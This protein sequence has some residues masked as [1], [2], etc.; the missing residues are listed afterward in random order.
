MRYSFL[1]GIWNSGRTRALPVYGP[2]GTRDIVFALLTQVY[3]ADIR[4][5]LKV[6]EYIG[7]Q[8]LDPNDLVRIIE[9]DHDWLLSQTACTFR[10]ER[11]M[12]GHTMGMSFEELPCLGYRLSDGDSTI[13]ISGDTVDCAGLEKLATDVDVLILCCYLT[14]DEEREGGNGFVSEHIMVSS[15]DAGK[16]ATKYRVKKLVLTHIRQ[17]SADMINKM[18][19]EIADDYSGMIVVGKDL[20]EFHVP[21]Y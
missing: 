13:A 6:A 17:K 2:K 11:V 21:D 3:S 15:A 18:A 16:I 20:L 19:R 1:L 9:I 8:L 4:F 12:H 5:R 7:E 14:R 10:C